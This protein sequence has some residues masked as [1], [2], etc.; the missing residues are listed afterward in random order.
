MKQTKKNPIKWKF[1]HIVTKK[2]ELRESIV[3]NSKS[4]RKQ[5]ADLLFYNK[6]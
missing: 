3:I 2:P 6:K 4:L 1:T 5:Y